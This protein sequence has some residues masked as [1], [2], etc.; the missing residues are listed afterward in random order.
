MRLMFAQ[1]GRDPHRLL[2]GYWHELGTPG[3]GVEEAIVLESQRSEELPMVRVDHR[4]DP[5]NAAL[6]EEGLDRSSHHR[7]AG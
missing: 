3:H 5:S 7:F 2:Q 1:H 6:I 4:Q